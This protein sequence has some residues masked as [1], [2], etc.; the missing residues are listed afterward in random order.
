M[1][2]GNICKL[3][4]YEFNNENLEDSIEKHLKEKHFLDYQDYYEIVKTGNPFECCWKCGK[5]RY[6]ISPW[7]DMFHLPCTHCVDFNNKH[8]LQ[9]LQ[10]SI[11]SNISNFQSCILRNKYYQYVLSLEPEERK[12][13]LPKS[14]S[15]TAENLMNLKKL[16]KTRIDRSNQIF[17]VTNPLGTSSE[18]SERNMMNLNLEVIDLKVTKDETGIFEIGDTGLYISLPEVVKFDIKHHS[19]NSI[20]NPSSKRSSKRLKMSNGDCIKFF[21]TPNPTTKS[22]LLLQNKKGKTINYEDLEEETKWLV[23]F[24]ILKTREILNR[25]FEIYNEIFKYLSWVD[26]HVFLL[27]SF[28]SPMPNL[29]LGMIFE[30]SWENHD[31]ENKGGEIIKLSII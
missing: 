25:I 28:K 9:E 12:R 6:T 26:D 17:K 27:N 8:F 20:L 1:D 3:C 30:W 10:E 24:G 31:Y 7:L 14:F 18:I 19:R 16:R 23:K 11:I 29:E 21:S 15:I 5:P 22:I 2:L 4:G 13:I